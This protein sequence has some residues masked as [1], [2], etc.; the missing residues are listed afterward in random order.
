MPSM[1]PLAMLQFAKEHPGALIAIVG[2]MLTSCL[3]VIG[4]FLKRIL[5]SSA[6]ADSSQ[7]K[8]LHD[9]MDLH[10]ADMQR[11]S[12]SMQILERKTDERLAELSRLLV[13]QFSRLTEAMRRQS[14]R[15][16]S[17]EGEHRVLAAVHGGALRRRE[18]HLSPDE[19]EK[20][21]S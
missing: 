4:F 5:D 21:N 20:D 2:F 11:Q 18:D 7:R 6:A 17:L 9:L 19:D 1:M 16:A 14:E 8:D 13:D 3:G 15:L 10:R 12:D